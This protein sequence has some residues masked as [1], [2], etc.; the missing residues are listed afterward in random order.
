MRKLTVIALILAIVGALN[1]GLVG[2]F[3]FNL[4][5]Y[6]FGPVS[7]FTRLIYILV[8]IAGLY[9]IDVLVRYVESPV[10]MM[11]GPLARET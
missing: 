6:L 3:G 4:V 7:W 11:G 5:A 2:F 1:W 8:G 10:P 9:T